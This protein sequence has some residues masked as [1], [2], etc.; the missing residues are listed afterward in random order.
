M[1]AAL[2]TAPNPFLTRL[3]HRT[4]IVADG[5]MGTRLAELGL[6]AGDA[7]E[8]WV[9]EPAGEAAVRAV[10]RAYREAGAQILLTIRS[11]PT[12]PGSLCTA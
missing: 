2:S 8:R 7:P 5:P 4:P 3:A 12:R 6:P 11:G 10:H 1:S 9:L